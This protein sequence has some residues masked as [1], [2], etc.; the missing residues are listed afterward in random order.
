L[1]VWTWEDQKN[2]I[3]KDSGMQ[4]RMI[5]P[6][7]C[8]VF[9]FGWAAHWLLHHNLDTPG[10]TRIYTIYIQ[11]KPLLITNHYI[12]KLLRTTCTTFGRKNTFGFD[13]HEIGNQKSIWFGAATTL[14]LQDVSTAAK[15]MII[16]HWSSHAFLVY[17]CQQ[18]L[19]WTNNMSKAMI[20]LNNFLDMG[21]HNYTTSKDPHM[22]QR[23]HPFNGSSILVPQF[24]LNH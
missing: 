17:I 5:D 19:K 22:H 15:I 11:G 3:K 18:V 16:G 21:C 6:V 10:P 24:H 13:A 9:C 20:H 1:A 12:R 23:L 8:S 2:G 4:Q 14:F 7:L